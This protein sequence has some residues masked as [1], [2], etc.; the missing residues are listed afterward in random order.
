MKKDYLGNFP[1]V[2]YAQ[3]ILISDVHMKAYCKRLG[4]GSDAMH[5]LLKIED[6]IGHTKEKLE[7]E[8]SHNRIVYS[9]CREKL[10]DIQKL[11]SVLSKKLKAIVI[12]GLEV[13]SK[14]EW[15]TQRILN[16]G[17]GG[18]KYREWRKPNCSIDLFEIAEYLQEIAD[19][20]DNGIRKIKGKKGVVWNPV[21]SLAME[22]IGAYRHFFKR[23]PAI[24]RES[25]FVQIIASIFAEA[26]IDSWLG[27][28]TVYK[29]LA[30]A[31][32]KKYKSIV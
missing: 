8:G 31:A 12:Q 15:K 10:A 22:I 24:Y 9:E 5:F 29:T 11:S 19:G 17:I 25:R 18:W 16:A 2:R 7:I 20:A 26:K 30:N 32:T 27:G 14:K 4:G 28:V 6:Y 23:E 13:H 21:D 3:K 1:N